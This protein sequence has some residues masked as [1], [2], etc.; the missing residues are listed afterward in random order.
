MSTF[1][2]QTL[3]DLHE[4]LAEMW[5]GRFLRVDGGTVAVLSLCPE[6]TVWCRDG[7]F[8]WYDGYQYAG[9]PVTDVLG[10]ADRIAARANE[11]S[12]QTS[13]GENPPEN[14]AVDDSPDS[15]EEEPPAAEV[16]ELQAT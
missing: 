2:S 1:Y 9:H 12:A 14:A 8:L 16:I 7:M 10:A 3:T 4:A 15:A 11:L 13:A 5:S 6:L